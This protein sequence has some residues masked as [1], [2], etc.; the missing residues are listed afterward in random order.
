MKNG[1]KKLDGLF[2]QPFPSRT[3]HTQAHA[4]CA[5]ATQAGQADRQTAVDGGERLAC[6]SLGRPRWGGVVWCGVVQS[7]PVLYCTYVLVS[8]LTI[9]AAE[10]ARVENLEKPGER[11]VR[12]WGRKEPVCPVRIVC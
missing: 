2:N 8:K 7:R 6:R 11:G 4:F 1:G 5:L 12:V 10:V 9:A 3:K